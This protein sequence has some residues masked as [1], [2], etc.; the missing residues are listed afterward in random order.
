MKPVAYDVS[1]QSA[2]SSVRK[3]TFKRREAAIENQL[4][5]AKVTFRKDKRR[6]SLRLGGQLGLSGQVASKE[7]L[8]DTTVGRIGHC[9]VLRGGGVRGIECGEARERAW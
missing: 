1:I 7:V 8:E 5:V 2:R 6:K 9:E 3:Q 4:Q